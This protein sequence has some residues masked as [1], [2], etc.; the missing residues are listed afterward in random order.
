MWTYFVQCARLTCVFWNSFFWLFS[1]LR[2]ILIDISSDFPMGH[3]IIICCIVYSAR[4]TGATWILM[5]ATWFYQQVA[6]GNLI[7]LGFVKAC[8]QPAKYFQ[9][10]KFK[11][12]TLPLFC[13][14]P[15]LWH[16]LTHWG[17][18]K[19]VAIFQMTFSNAFFNENTRIL[20][21]II[22]EVYS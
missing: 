18:D 20:I 14:K 1:I 10:I 5:G 22:T 2:I 7:F 21:K 12:Y 13:A 3:K 6:M 4:Q 19:M 9:F 11:L 15:E 16:C 17:R 8:I